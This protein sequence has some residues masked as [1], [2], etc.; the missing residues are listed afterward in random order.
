MG[1]YVPSNLSIPI[2]P[3]TTTAILS[4]THNALIAGKLLHSSFWAVAHQGP[5][6]LH[7]SVDFDYGTWDLLRNFPPHKLFRALDFL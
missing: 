7:V 5:P 4:Q 6:L 2:P 3:I 1:H